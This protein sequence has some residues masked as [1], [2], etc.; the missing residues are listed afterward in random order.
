M[1]D[2]QSTPEEKI[3]YCSSCGHPNLSWRSVC[4][5]CRAR[6]VTPD[7]P[8]I[9][10]QKQ[11]PGCVTAYAVLLWIV[12]ALVGIG[13]PIAGFAL[14]DEMGDGALLALFISVAAIGAAALNVVIGWGLWRLN[15]A[16][17]LVIVF[18]SL[19]VVS[20]LASLCLALGVSSGEVEPT[21]LC[22]TIGGLA[23]NGYIIYWFA[24]NSEHFG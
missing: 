14:A 20:S 15:W 23:V 11:R 4:E 13:G 2:S 9:P 19:G 1:D 22:S 8:Y 17:I 16:R 6:L 5:N 10:V 18:Q 24:S 21:S 7:K 12:A 3:V